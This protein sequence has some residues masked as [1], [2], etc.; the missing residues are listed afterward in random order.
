MDN[1]R[2]VHRQAPDIA[3][4]VSPTEICSGKVDERMRWTSIEL[5]MMGTTTPPKSIL[6]PNTPVHSL[7]IDRAIPLDTHQDTMHEILYRQVMLRY[8]TSSTV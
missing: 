7:T 4:G 5:A 2:E 3:E 1:E 8:K 6:S